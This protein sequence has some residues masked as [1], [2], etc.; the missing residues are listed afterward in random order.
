[1][2][3]QATRILNDLENHKRCWDF[4]VDRLAEDTAET[5]ALGMFIQMDYQVDPDN[6]AWQR[7]NEK[8]EAWKRKNVPGAKIS[9]LEGHM[10]AVEQLKGYVDV[11]PDGMEQNYGIDP[12][13]SDEAVWFQEGNDRQPPREFYALSDIAIQHL[14]ALF[15]VRFA[16]IVR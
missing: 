8:Y 2:S 10:K 5:A 11:L 16:S 14:D 7:L 12:Q 4:S 1:M 13:A 3:A 6:N 9:E 15:D